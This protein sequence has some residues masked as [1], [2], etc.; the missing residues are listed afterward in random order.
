MGFYFCT[1]SLAFIVACKNEGIVDT[2]SIATD[3]LRVAQGKR[4][5]TQQCAACHSFPRKALGL[6]WGPDQRSKH[7]VDKI[8]YPQP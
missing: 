3:S 8:V 1:L 6:H 2:S 7:R 5:F 4:L